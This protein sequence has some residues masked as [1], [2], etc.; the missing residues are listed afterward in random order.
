MDRSA[1][2]PR[3]IYLMWKVNQAMRTLIDHYGKGEG[4]T[5]A[6]YTAL[7]MLSRRPGLTGAELAREISVSP[8]SANEIVTAL[9]NSGLLIKE[10]APANRKAW[11][12]RLTEAG[13]RHLVLLEATIDLAEAEIFKG[14]PEEDLALVRNLMSEI[15]QKARRLQAEKACPDG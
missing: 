10:R 4:V 15:L 7:W 14:T 1:P 8:Q 12:L 5:L 6:Q 9:H 13:E 11:R 3:T 2:K